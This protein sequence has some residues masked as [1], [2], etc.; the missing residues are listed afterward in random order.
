MN[1]SINTGSEDNLK[2]LKLYDAQIKNKKS[3][4]KNKKKFKRKKKKNSTTF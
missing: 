1:L 2:P 3:Q 4:N